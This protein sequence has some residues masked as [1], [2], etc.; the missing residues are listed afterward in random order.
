MAELFAAFGIDWKLLLAQ[1]VN[2]L[3]VFGGLTYFLYKPL[4]RALA[5]REEKIAKGVKDAEEAE[6]TPCKH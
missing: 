4:M 6:A 2:F 1:S 5:A 3:I